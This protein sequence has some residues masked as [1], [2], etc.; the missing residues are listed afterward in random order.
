MDSSMIWFQPGLAAAEDAGAAAAERKAGDQQP[1]E[2]FAG[3]GGAAEQGR[4]RS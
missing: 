4:Q 3:A 1:A 2:V